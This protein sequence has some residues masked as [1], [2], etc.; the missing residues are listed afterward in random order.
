MIFNRNKVA[1]QYP[2]KGVGKKKNLNA[3]IIKD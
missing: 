1:W 3:V 2:P